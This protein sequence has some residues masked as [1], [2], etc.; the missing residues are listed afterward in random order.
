M[1]DK[2]YH[3][4]KPDLC[5]LKLRLHKF[6]YIKKNQV[7]LFLIVLYS[8]DTFFAYLQYIFGEIILA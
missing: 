5:Y 6:S 1:T 7:I 3:Q 2:I 8:S 4:I